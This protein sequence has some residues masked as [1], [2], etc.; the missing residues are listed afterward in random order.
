MRHLDPARFL[1]GLC[2]AVWSGEKS[3]VRE[4]PVQARWHPCWSRLRK[5]VS[6][7]RRL[8]HTSEFSSKGA[9]KGEVSRI[10]RCRYITGCPRYTTL[11]HPPLLS[12][13][14]LFFLLHVGPGRPLLSVLAG[15]NRKGGV[16]GNK[17]SGCL[18]LPP[19]TPALM[20]TSQRGPK[21]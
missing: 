4:S 21:P 11:S 13:A 14:D 19:N 12:L 6:E 17:L 20:S 10:S 5:E 18:P 2:K 8:S 16:E 3:R 1:Q 9:L 15:V 7:H